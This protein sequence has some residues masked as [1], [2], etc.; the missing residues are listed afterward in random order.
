[1]NRIPLLRIAFMAVMIHWSAAPVIAQSK[2]EKIDELMGLYTEYGQFNG[3]VLV[4]ENGSVLYSNGFGFA[5]M[6]WDIQNKPNTKFRLGSITKQFT[7]MLVVQLAEQGKI[8]LQANVS[9]YLPN[10]PKAS[11]EKITIHHLLT[12]TSGIPNYTSFR[13]FMRGHSRDFYTPDEFV[14]MF[15]DSTLEFVPGEKFAYSNSGYF[16]LGVIIEKVSGTS[17]EQLLQENIL[18]PLKM[19]DTGYDHFGTILPNRASGYEKRG[20]AYVNADYLD[21]SIP[22]AAGSLYSTVEDLFIWDQ[23]LYTDQLLSAEFMDLMFK[24]YLDGY[25]YGWGVGIEV[26]GKNNDSLLVIRHGGGIN[27]FNTLISRVP[28]DKNT[29]ILLNNTGG[30]ALSNMNVAISSILYEQPYEL[31]KRSAA[32]LL[33]EI[34]T[35]EGLTAGLQRFKEISTSEEFSVNE[36]EMNIA[37][38]QLMGS[39]KVTEAIEVFK[40]NVEAFPKSGNVYDSLGEAYLEAGEKELAI[41]NYARSVEIDPDNVNGLKILEE[42]RSE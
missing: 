5:N 12:H 32:E 16:L 15:A 25:A 13:N 31:P 24:P 8:D 14:R 37:G 11:G 20:E 34:I 39:G 36:R 3:S 42:L 33:L 27:G 18:T 40:L 9:T 6:E 29:V 26:I 22:Y 7:A 41:K 21:M 17:Y 38:Y 28:A 30:A 35:T 23:A 4:A 10:Y 1:M 19:E 2:A